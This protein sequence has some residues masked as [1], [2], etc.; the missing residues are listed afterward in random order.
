MSDPVANRTL[1]L[2]CTVGS[3]A[4]AIEAIE[5]G[6]DV[7]NGGGAPLFTAIFNHNPA[8]VRVLIEH[9]A[10]LSNFLTPARRAGLTEIDEIIAMLMTFAPPDPKA[11]DPTL[12]EETDAILKKGGLGKPVEDGEWEGLVL[13]AEKLE[14]IG[15]TES[16]AAL[17]ELL[18][19]LRPAWSFGTAA[20]LASIKA[21]KKKVA[22]LSQRYAEAGEDIGNLAQAFLG[23]ATQEP[24]PPVSEEE[25]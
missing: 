5:D 17:T 8:V 9:G 15:A 12:M 2:A 3:V 19:L 23:A 6:A 22:A 11:I 20:L 25:E 13:Y 24:V 18:D 21:E 14:K 16:H 4:D 7:N 1:D 10:D